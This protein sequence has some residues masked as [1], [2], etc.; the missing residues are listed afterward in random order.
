MAHGTTIRSVSDLYRVPERFSIAEILAM[1]T[2]YGLLFGALRWLGASAAL[3]LFLGTQA[4]MVCVAQMWWGTV[5]RGASMLVGAV[6]F[7]LWIGALILLGQAEIAARADEFWI[8]TL[9]VLVAGP[10]L[11]YCTGTLA[12]GVF[13]VMDRWTDFVDRSRPTAGCSGTA[14]AD[15]HE[16]SRV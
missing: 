2:V 3:Y 11:G 15:G 8:D 12:A 9:T 10:L 5:P 6:L 14:A 13:L 7:P 4:L 1:M 16:R